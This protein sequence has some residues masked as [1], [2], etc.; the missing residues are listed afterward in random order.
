MKA[1]YLPCAV[2][3]AVLVPALCSRATTPANTEQAKISS[4][5]SYRG[6]NT[7]TGQGGYSKVGFPPDD[8]AVGRVHWKASLPA[9]F[10]SEAVIGDNDLCYVTVSSARTTSVYAVDTVFGR[11]QWSQTTA[12]TATSL[13]TSTPATDGVKVYVASTDGKVMA[14]DAAGG[15]KLWT[16]DVPGA[17]PG[18]L[19]TSSPKVDDSF[20]YAIFEDT[21]YAIDKQTGELK[22]QRKV[23]PIWTAEAVCITGGRVFVGGYENAVALNAQ[24]GSVL[25]EAPV[26]GLRS[27]VADGSHIYIACRDA[28]V[29]CLDSSSGKLLWSIK[30]G[31][32]LSGLAISRGSVLVKDTF[33]QTG[34]LY[35]LYAD[36]GKIKWTYSP[37]SGSASIAVDKDGVVYTTAMPKLIAI[38]TGT[39]KKKWTLNLRHGV[40]PTLYSPTVGPDGTVYIADGEGVLYS[41]Q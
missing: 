23:G 31:F 27:P 26:P 30:L 40:I 2:A 18:E 1:N 36:T 35:A 25:W 13:S 34:H 21:L 5:C 10:T 16:Y 12:E 39:G 38:H 3:F 22:W 11:V 9:G 41:V 33:G 15:R 32:S 17:K 4:W 14:L 29:R 8:G 20:V 19:N 7:N 6:G 28:R 24:D 37:V